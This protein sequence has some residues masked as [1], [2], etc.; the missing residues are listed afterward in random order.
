M[1]GL[2]NDERPVGLVFIVTCD[3]S[4]N[5]RQQVRERWAG[6][7]ECRFWTG[8]E[9]DAKAKQHPDIV[10]EFFQAEYRFEHGLGLRVGLKAFLKT[11]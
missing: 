3:V 11:A 1:L 9:L 5:A 4:A 7:M 8:T 2:S 10:A 6:E